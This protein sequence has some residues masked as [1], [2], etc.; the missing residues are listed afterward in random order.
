M[1]LRTNLAHPLNLLIK[2]LLEHIRA[3]SIRVEQMQQRVHKAKNI[4]YRF[5]IEK[6]YEPLTLCMGPFNVG[7]TLRA[8]W[9]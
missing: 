7:E 3:Y 4:Y 1:A 6:V 9:L 8:S 2:I 5:L